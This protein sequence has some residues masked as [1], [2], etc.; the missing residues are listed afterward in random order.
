MSQQVSTGERPVILVT[1]ATGAQGGSVARSLL[2]TNRY[3]VRCLTRNTGSDKARALGKA[4]AQLAEG[5]LSDM[6]SLLRAMQGC[7]GVFGVTNFWE[8]FEKEFQQ[9]KNL[10]D[11]V[12]ES[13]IRHFV[14][15]SLPSY[16]ELSTGQFPVPHCDIKAALENYSRSL[17]LPATFV[18]IAFYYENF[19]T[20]FPPQRKEDGIYYFGFPQGDTRLSMASVDDIGPIV[21]QIFAC[22]EIYLGRTVGVVGED[23]TCKEYAA[24]MS[25]VLGITIRYNHIQRDIFSGFDFPGAE[26]LANMFE[27]QRLHIP[28]RSQALMESYCMN[29][30]MQSFE[31]WLEKNKTPFLQLLNQTEY[32]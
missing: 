32:A 23:R 24:I 13:G 26:E 10:V 3:T 12:N 9:G 6:E 1:G 28:R 21:K 29:P 30:A 18:H 31:S 16:V 8:H 19:F 2:Q 7:S 22:P 4:G 5:D 27:V 11:A 17:S 14:Y 20:F 15:S 25:R